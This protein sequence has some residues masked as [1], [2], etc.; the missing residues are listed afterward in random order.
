ML[1]K[2]GKGRVG[3][4][5]KGAFVSQARKCRFAALVE[6]LEKTITTDVIGMQSTLGWT[7]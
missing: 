6:A 4:S 7:L 2:I 5:F 1:D 3:R